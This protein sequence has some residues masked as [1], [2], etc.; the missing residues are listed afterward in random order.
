MGVAPGTAE[1][2]AMLNAGLNY[3]RVQATHLMIFPGLAIVATVLGI[4]L[5]GDDLRDLWDPRLRS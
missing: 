4:N 2:G 1:W 5:L 3:M